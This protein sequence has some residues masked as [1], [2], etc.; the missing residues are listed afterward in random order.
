VGGYRPLR[1]EGSKKGVHT[2]GEFSSRLSLARRYTKRK[3]GA[4]SQKEFIIVGRGGDKR[5]KEGRLRYF[6]LSEKEITHLRMGRWI[7]G[8]DQKR[9]E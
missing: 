1:E 7:R 2:R 8:K 6:A 9:K 5:S 3:R 4:T